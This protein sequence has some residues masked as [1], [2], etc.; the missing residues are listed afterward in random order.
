MTAPFDPHLPAAPPAPAAGDSHPSPFARSPEKAA[1]LAA[2]REERATLW[3][4]IQEAGGIAGWVRAELGKKG[5]S[6]EGVDPAA[7]TDKQKGAYKEKKRAE[8]EARR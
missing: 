8:A 6:T 2:Q 5:V 3:K 4:A 7:L 1:R